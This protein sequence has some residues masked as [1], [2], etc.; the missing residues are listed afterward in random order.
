MIDLLSPFQ[1]A[2]DPR[3]P[4]IARTVHEVGQLGEEVKGQQRVRQLAQPRLEDARHHVDVGPLVLVQNVGPAPIRRT[5]P[6]T[7]IGGQVSRSRHRPRVREY[8]RTVRRQSAAAGARHPAACRTRGRCPPSRGR[9]SRR[10]AC[11]L[12]Q[13]QAAPCPRTSSR[14]AARQRRRLCMHR[15]PIKSFHDI[16]GRRGGLGGGRSTPTI[17]MIRPTS[18]VPRPGAFARSFATRSRSI[19]P[20]HQWSSCGATAT[21]CRCWAQHRAPGLCSGRR[22]S[23]WSLAVARAR[24][25]ARPRCG[26]CRSWAPRS[27]RTFCGKSCCRL[28]SSHRDGAGHAGMQAAIDQSVS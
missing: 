27:A 14:P 24:P 1:S 3:D 6:T 11:T 7:R 4:I 21:S 10:H 15:R 22:P 26:P 28:E 18:R 25:R 16:K 8:G 23:P 20:Y 5:M 19:D 17:S 9:A 12:P 2:P 13:S